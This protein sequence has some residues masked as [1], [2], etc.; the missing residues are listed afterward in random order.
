MVDTTTNENTTQSSVEKIDL[1][2]QLRFGLDLF[3]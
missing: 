3:S 1:L 2:D